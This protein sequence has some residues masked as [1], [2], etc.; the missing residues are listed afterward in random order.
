MQK[1]SDANKN[2]VHETKQRHWKMI[3][4]LFCSIYC[5]YYPFYNFVQA[6]STHVVRV[7]RLET[8]LSSTL[9]VI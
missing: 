7:P 6:L 4:I 9:Y 3:S 5:D 8:V 1:T 2:W